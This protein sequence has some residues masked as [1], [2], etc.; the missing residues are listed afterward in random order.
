[1][2]RAALVELLAAHEPADAEEAA[3]LERMRGFAASLAEPFSREQPE[4][5]FTASAL[6]SDEAGER[7][8]LVHHRRSGSWFQP[9]GHFERS[10]ISAAEA[11]LREAREET[12]LAVRLGRSGLLDVDVHWVPWDEHYHLDLRFYVV[13]SGELAPDATE[14]HAAEWLTWEEAFARIGEH[15]LRRALAKGSKAAGS[16]LGEGQLRRDER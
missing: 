1:M 7:T 8:L 13:A 6:V 9:G 3:D 15:A 2:T 10:D 5:H 12:G 4:A 16:R 14:V 11:A